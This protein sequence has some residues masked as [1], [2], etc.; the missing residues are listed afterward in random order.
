MWMA[1]LLPFIMYIPMNIFIGGLTFEECQYTANNFYSVFFLGL[2]FF[3]PLFIYLWLNGVAKHYNPNEDASIAKLNKA[4]KIAE[5]LSFAIPVTLTVIN[6]IVVTKYNLNHGFTPASFRGESYLFFSFC[7]IFGG[8]CVFSV[9]SYILIVSGLVKSV[10]WLPYKREYM[11]FSFLQRCLLISF[12]VL[13]GMVLLIEAIF[14]IPA[15][16]DVP[17]TILLSTKV[18]PFAC[19]IGFTGVLDMYLQL[20]DV[21]RCIKCI[22]KFSEDLSN[23]NYQTEDIPVLIRC[24]LGELANYL[25]SLRDSTKT[26]L[27]DLKNSVDSTAR[28]SEALGREMESVQKDV[29]AINA[30]IDSVHNEMKNQASGVD[31]TSTSVNQI[32]DRT[33]VL[34][35]NIEGQVSAVTQSSSAVE[36][37]VANINSVNQILSQN[38]KTVNSLSNASDDGRKSVESAVITS[39]QIIEQSATLM[40]ATSIIQNIASQTNLLAMNAAI[41]SAH[42][43][44]AGKGF[45]VVADEIR[46]LAEQSSAQGKTINDNL[47]DLSSSIELVSSNTKEVQEKFNVIYDLAQTVMRQE[48]VIMSAMN[49]Q[50]E[51]NKQVLDAIRAIN[52][53]SS[54]VKN[55]SV[56]MVAG[57]Q[58]IVKEMSSLSEITK[59]INLEMEGMTSRI[60]GIAASVNN[61]SKTTETNKNQM[62]LLSEQIGNFKL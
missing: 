31:E 32:I 12:F 37:M 35:K 34:N 43:G 5:F 7:M 23:K 21:N 55:G 38:T 42:A 22:G 4:V 62:M 57:G 11:T 53:S 59:N 58:Q 50:A 39:Q 44:A 47:K 14:E 60:Q 26:L 61:V 18:T 49:E 36:E 33:E 46:K 48:N 41:E 51:G 25:N 1:F 52:S 3:A 8:L 40:E 20:R 24:E 17:M 10:D 54:D 27:S 19:I 56:K 13:L 15:N 2:S 6:P 30:G 45:A 29:E 9:F 28:L 16:R